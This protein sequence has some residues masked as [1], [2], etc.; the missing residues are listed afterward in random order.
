MLAHLTLKEAMTPSAKNA[1]TPASDL[2]G[3]EVGDGWIIT[4]RL[5]RA[6]EPDAEDLTGSWFSIGYIASKGGKKAFVKVIDIQRA[7]EMRTS[8]LSI[9]DRLKLL[10]ESHS[11]ECAILDVCN[12]ARMDRVVRV[13]GRGELEPLEGAFPIEIPYIMFELADGGDVRKVV[14]RSSK[15]EDAWRFRVLHDVAVGIQQLHGQEIAHQDIKPS[16]VLIFGGKGSGAKLGDLGRASRRGTEANHD[17]EY[18]AGAPRYAPPEQVFGV[19]PERW[20]DRR[21]GCDLYHLGSLATFLFAGVTPAAYYAQSLSADMK[22]KLWGGSGGCD[23]LTALPLLTSTFTQFAQSIEADLPSWAAPELTQ[24]VLTACNPDYRLRGD[25]AARRR[26]GSPV[27]IETY[28]SRF[29]R[30][31]KHANI[32]TRT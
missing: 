5:P 25:P 10:T 31:A 19:R 23:Y 1:E 26:A 29:D 16:N 24:I 13:L 9:I 28:V 20:E 3:R 6:G 7:I 18:I 27:G 32:K 4:E 15:V 11:F 2:I 21:E 14:G 22:P 30:L 12:K 17:A 8:E